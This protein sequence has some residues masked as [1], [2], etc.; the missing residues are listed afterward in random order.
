[1]PRSRGI[2]PEGAPSELWEFFEAHPGST[3][4]DAIA[5]LKLHRSTAYYALA[6][7]FDR[8][9]IEPQRKKR[10][11]QRKGWKVIEKEPATSSPEP[12]DGVA[13]PEPRSPASPSPIFTSPMIPHATGMP[14]SVVDG[15]VCPNKGELQVFAFSGTEPRERDYS[16]KGRI[17]AP[18]AEHPWS[19][20]SKVRGSS[21]P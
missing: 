18:G 16:R 8:G 2:L 13:I 11:G 7:L 12:D 9:L 10:R 4:D 19:Y 14:Y 3:I 6:R 5:A 17:N 20:A 21:G 1:V 15:R